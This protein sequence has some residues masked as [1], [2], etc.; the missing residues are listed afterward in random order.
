MS[1]RTCSV[2]LPGVLGV[3]LV[4]RRAHFE[5]LARVDLDVGRLAF[6]ARRGLVDQ[7]PRVGQHRA[8]AL[9][10]AASSSEPIDIAT[11]THIVAMSGLTKFIVS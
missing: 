11:P 7:D 10:P 3:D 1:G 2:G 9:R 6:E 5:D 8:L 4:D